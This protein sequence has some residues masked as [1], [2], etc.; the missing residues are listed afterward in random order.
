MSNNGGPSS[1]NTGATHGVHLRLISAS[2][3]FVHGHGLANADRASSNNTGA[4]H[5][6]H[7]RL[8]SARLALVHDLGIAIGGNAVTPFGVRFIF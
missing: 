7:L 5:G 4:T 8:I 2:F 3:A 6:V 1:N